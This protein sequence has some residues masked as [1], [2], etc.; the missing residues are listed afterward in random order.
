MNVS[1]KKAA[2]TE[3]FKEMINIDEEFGSIGLGHVEMTKV[4]EKVEKP[5]DP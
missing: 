1:Y 3:D 5:R 2:T 4:D